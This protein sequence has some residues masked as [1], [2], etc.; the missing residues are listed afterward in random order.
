MWSSESS[1]SK[2]IHRVSTSK[3]RYYRS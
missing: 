3:I 1:Q 2:R